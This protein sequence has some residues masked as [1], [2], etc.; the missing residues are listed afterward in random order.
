MGD[1]TVR[2]ALPAQGAKRAKG[3][4][5]LRDLLR[6]LI[7][8]RPVGAVSGAIVLLLCLVAIFADVLAPFHFMDMTVTFAAGEGEEAAAAEKEMVLD[9]S[10]GEMVTAPE[11]GGTIRLLTTFK[12]E[13]IDPY[14]HGGLDRRGSVGLTAR[15]GEHGAGPPPGGPAPGCSKCSRT[16]FAGDAIGFPNKSPKVRTIPCAAAR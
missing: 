7:R 3:Q 9:P 4:S 1:V 13:G 14:Y 11:Y 2:Q 16:T 8:E 6:R 5:F 12:P 10:T 15:L